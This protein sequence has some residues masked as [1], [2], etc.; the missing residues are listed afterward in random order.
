MRVGLANTGDRRML[1]VD[2]HHIISDGISNEILVNEFMSLYK[3]DSLAPLPIQYK[4]FAMWQMDNEIEGG[5][6]Q[7]R[8]YWLS[9][10]EGEIPQLNLPLDYSRPAI[11]DFDGGAVTFYIESRETDQLKRMASNQGVTLYMTLL[12]LINILFSK[13]GNQEDIII[14]SPVSGRNHADLENIIGVFI[15]TLALRNFPGARLPSPLF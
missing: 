10:F 8:L 11:Q 7:Q 3:G 12:A 4:D 13:L 5:M 6:K 14:G 2:M 1:L 15:N 9:Q